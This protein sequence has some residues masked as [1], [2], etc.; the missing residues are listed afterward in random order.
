MTYIG[1]L[2]AERERKGA[3]ETENCITMNTIGDL[4]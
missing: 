2:K 1:G 3:E 4:G